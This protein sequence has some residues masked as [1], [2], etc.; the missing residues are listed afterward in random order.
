MTNNSKNFHYTISNIFEN[1]L[2]IDDPAYTPGSVVNWIFEQARLDNIRDI[3]AMKLQKLLYFMHGN[4][5]RSFNKPLVN[6]YAQAWD[7]G[8]VFPSVYHEYKTN[9]S[10]AIPLNDINLMREYDT[11][12][13]KFVPL[14]VN[15]NDKET[16]TILRNTWEKY[17]DKSASYLSDLTHRPDDDNPWIIIRNISKEEKISNISTPNSIIK[18]YFDE[19]NDL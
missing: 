14:I 19:N 5:L 11:N 18:K 2:K 8:P 1:E 17:K 9:G 4:Y 13:K 12:I 15:R 10:K 6:E 3:S 16:I 7:Y